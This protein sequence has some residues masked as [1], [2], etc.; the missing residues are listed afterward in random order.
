MTLI[1]SK[2][3]CN[4]MTW[5][6]IRRYRSPII[7]KLITM[8]KRSI[9]QKLR[10][11]NFDARNERTETEQW[12]R[13]EG[14]NVVLKEDQENAISGKQKDSVREEAN[15]VSRTMRISVQNRHQKPL[16]P[17]VEVRRGK[18]TSKA[19]DH[20]GSLLDSGAKTTSSDLSSS[21]DRIATEQFLAGVSQVL[22]DTHGC[23]LYRVGYLFGKS[24]LFN[25]QFLREI[26]I[27]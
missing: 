14:V 22:V 20:L 17:L 19:G 9:D 4:C 13:N 16:H 18:R 1:N 3:Y 8:V 5:K 15:V 12:L 24:H 10:L 27:E 26:V 2:T 11:R 21:A 25:M 6:F 7:K 23:Q